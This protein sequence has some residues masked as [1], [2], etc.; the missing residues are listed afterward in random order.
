ML[1]I[2]SSYWICSFLSLSDRCT[3]SDP[4]GIR[5]DP[6]NDAESMGLVSELTVVSADLDMDSS[7]TLWS[8]S[9]AP[10]PSINSEVVT[11]FPR[12]GFSILSYLMF[13]ITVLSVFNNCLVI[14]VI[15]RNPS[16]L[17]PMNVFIL[18]LAVSDLM[19]GL[20]G[21][22]VV[23]ITNYHGSFF[24]GHAACVFQG[25]AVNYFGK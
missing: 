5:N 7:S 23:T 1:W 4:T 15:L 12:F 11:V 24:I 14:T 10:P 17:Q 13:I 6:I 8:S 20:C 18:S 21:S 9:S 16:V 25:F 3:I 19:I 2:S 22:L